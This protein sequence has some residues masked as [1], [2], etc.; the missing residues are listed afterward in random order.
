MIELKGSQGLVPPAI[1]R[2]VTSLATIQTR[3]T[4]IIRIPEID[5][6]TIDE[7]RDLHRVASLI[8][9]EINVGKWRRETIEA[10]DPSSMEIGEHIQIQLD[11]PLRVKVGDDIL[12]VGTV[13]QTILS[14]IV[15]GID[16]TTTRVEP[17]LNDTV[18]E[19]LV[20]DP[21]G[22]WAPSGKTAVRSRKYPTADPRPTTK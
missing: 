20:D 6:V 19:R 4:Q 3:T 17:N 15:V 9:G 1:D 11:L 10:V 14:A 18:H 2:F 12:E 21:D 16:G 8:N 7:V 22:G 13:E 5:G